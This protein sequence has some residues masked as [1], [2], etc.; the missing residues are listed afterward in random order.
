MA[1]PAHDSR[2]YEFATKFELPI[3]QV[4]KPNDDSNIDLSKEAFT[5]VSTG[6][7]INSGFLDGLSVTDAKKKVIEYL[8][9]NSIGKKK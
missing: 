3:I 1:V 7:L 4:V 8:E 9:E 2:D 5:D 6:I